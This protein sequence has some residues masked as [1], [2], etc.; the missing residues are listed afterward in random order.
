MDALNSLPS[1]KN[2]PVVE[3]ALAVEFAPLEG[4]SALSYGPLWDCFREEYPFTEVQQSLAFQV[5]LQPLSPGKGSLV[6][7][8]LPARYFFKNGDGSELIQVRSGAFV[9]NWRA[10]PELPYPRY[11]ERIRPAFERD[12]QTFL[13]YL[14]RRNY[15]HPEVWKCEVTYVNH[16]TRGK[17]WSAWD[18]V[19]ALVPSL[20][21]SANSIV[22][23]SLTGAQCVCNYKIWDGTGD[24]IIQM[25]PGLTQDGTEVVQFSLAASGPPQSSDS[26]HLMEMLD[27][28]HETIVTN[29][30]ELMA[31]DVQTAQWGRIWQ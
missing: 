24:L 30:A 8:E 9:R 1:Y 13:D 15:P 14:K 16:F 21:P 23:G 20:A 28:G 29:F 18:D 22:H 31:A 25:M 11:G 12:F 6:P 17:E 4:W 5:P 10:M 19:P 27:R 2:P 26:A 3:V 7:N